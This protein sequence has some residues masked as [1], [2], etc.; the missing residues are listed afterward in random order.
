[1]LNLNGL[2]RDF[3]E[4]IA[5]H[6]LHKDMVL[7]GHTMPNTDH[8]HDLYSGRSVPVVKEDWGRELLS[9]NIFRCEVDAIVSLLMNHTKKRID[10]PLDY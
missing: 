6:L 9:C 1:M 2:S 10:E 5:R 3:T 8:W 4:I 7:R